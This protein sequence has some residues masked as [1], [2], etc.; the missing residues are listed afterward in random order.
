M[1]VSK[2]APQTSLVRSGPRGQRSRSNR[3]SNLTKFM[4]FGLNVTSGKKKDPPVLGI[5]FLSPSLI[6]S[7]SLKMYMYKHGFD[8]WKK[9]QGK[10]D[11]YFESKAWFHW[12]KIKTKNINFTYFMTIL[13]IVPQ[14]VLNILG[15]P[16]YRY[17]KHRLL[18]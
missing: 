8:W 15:L 11:C 12:L 3:R 13:F 1:L 7:S 9:V 2:A 4:D 5:P 18:T 10:G 14:N 16:S 17:K 6:I